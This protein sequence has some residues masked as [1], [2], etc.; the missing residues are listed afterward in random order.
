MA[1]RRRKKKTAGKKAE[2]KAREQEA[3]EE[4]EEEEEYEVEQI[5]Y[6]KQHY[7]T[8]YF[9]YVKW[10]GYDESD[11][12]WEPYKNLNGCCQLR[13]SYHARIDQLEKEDNKA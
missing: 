6:H 7:K 4:E 10:K 13:D 3:L 8:N 12:T 2:E 5:L 11:N 1:G 9:Y